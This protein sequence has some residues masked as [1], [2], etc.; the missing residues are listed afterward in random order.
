MHSLLEVGPLM[1]PHDTNTL[2]DREKKL[3]GR[4]DDLSKQVEEIRRLVPLGDPLNLLLENAQEALAAAANHVSAYGFV[5]PRMAVLSTAA[6]SA[7]VAFKSKD[8]A[9]EAMENL[10]RVIREGE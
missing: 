1:P 10:A 7:Y 6:A 2:A 9:P 5:Q 4:A 3:E 8:N